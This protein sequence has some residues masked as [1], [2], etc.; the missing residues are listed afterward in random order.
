MTTTI[1]ALDIPSATAN[2]YGFIF[3]AIL[4]GP[5]LITFIRAKGIIARIIGSLFMLPF[6]IFLA[7]VWALFGMP[8]AFSGAITEEISE[9]YV[10]EHNEN[11]LESGNGELIPTPTLEPGENPFDKHEG[12]KYIYYEKF[13]CVPHETL[14]PCPDWV[15]ELDMHDVISGNI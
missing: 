10:E 13:G 15:L 11:V 4:L 14:Y 1:H 7:F 12:Y 8:F 6:S 3:W 9:K 5:P 2:I